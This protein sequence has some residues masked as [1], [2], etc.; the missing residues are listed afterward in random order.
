MKIIKSKKLYNSQELSTILEIDQ[1]IVEKYISERYIIGTKIGKLWWV[2]EENLNLFLNGYYLTRNK[3]DDI[4]YSL[5]IAFNLA[6]E[7][8]DISKIKMAIQ[9]IQEMENTIKR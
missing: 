5:Y 9:T 6:T 4:K 8:E 3:I 7:K 2:T 1:K